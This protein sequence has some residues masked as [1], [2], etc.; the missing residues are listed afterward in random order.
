MKTILV[1]VLFQVV[2]LLRP[3]SSLQI[4]FLLFYLLSS[5]LLMSLWN[6]DDNDGGIV[7]TKTAHSIGRRIE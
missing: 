3:W 6:C 4:V 7:L 5:C 1:L 2:F